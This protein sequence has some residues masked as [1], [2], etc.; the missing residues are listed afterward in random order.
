M[1]AKPEIASV[2]SRDWL[3]PIPASGWWATYD[4]GDPDRVVS[5][6]AV[7]VDDD[8]EIL[9]LVSVRGGLVPAQTAQ[10][11]VAFVHESDL[12]VGELRKAGE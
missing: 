7:R 8:V 3:F 9:G 6:V 10:N 11:F 12:A 5:F 1:I 2:H 4:G